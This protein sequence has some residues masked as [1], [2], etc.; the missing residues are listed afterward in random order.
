MWNS[1]SAYF[2][3]KLFYKGHLLTDEQ[4]T[5]NFCNR[6]SQSLKKGL[7]MMMMNEFL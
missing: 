2:T 7:M 5:A 6:V 4:R 1:S 3:I